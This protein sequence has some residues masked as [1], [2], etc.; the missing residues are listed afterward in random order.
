MLELNYVIALKC[1]IQIENLTFAM[2]FMNFS[3]L[4]VCGQINIVLSLSTSLL[5]L[6]PLINQSILCL[7]IFQMGTPPPYIM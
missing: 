6:Y 2:F 7:N 3:K 4:H 5:F 1:K